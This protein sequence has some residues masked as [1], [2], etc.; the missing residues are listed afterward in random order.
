MNA[1]CPFSAFSSHSKS[2]GE[3]Y[4]NTRFSDRNKTH[5]SHEIQHFITKF[6]VY[7]KMK[8]RKKKPF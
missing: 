8:K 3:K 6:H 4:E 1:N 2:T 5:N 7:D